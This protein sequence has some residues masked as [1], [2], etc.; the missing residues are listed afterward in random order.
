MLFVQVLFWAD[1]AHVRTG[2]LYH[3]PDPKARIDLSISP[4]YRATAGTGTIGLR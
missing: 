1:F 2:V 3:S 4:W